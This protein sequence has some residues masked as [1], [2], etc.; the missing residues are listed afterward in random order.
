MS[1]A[2]F[3]VADFSTH[4]SGPVCSQLL[5]ELG[6]DVVKIENPR[7]GDGNR[8]LT[9]LIHDVGS[10]HIAMSSGTRSLAI[11]R[12]SPHWDDVVAA[13][14]RW[15]DAV[16]VGSRPI[17]AQARGLDFATVAKANP[18]I[19]YCLIT[20]YGEAG[21][22]KDY[23]AH[24]QNMDALAGLVPL[25]WNDGM[26]ATRPGFRTAGTTLAGIYAALGVM[27]GL[28]EQVREGGS[29]YVRVSV[30]GS[31]MAWQWRD[32]VNY[33]N[34]GEPWFEYR[35][36]GSRY[37][38]YPTSDE[39]AL[40]VC[41]I[42]RKF[43]QQFCAVTGLEQL[44]DRGSW[45][46]S[47]MDFGRGPDSED[48]RRTIAERLRTR[49]LSAWVEALEKTTIPFAPILTTQE[50]LQSE[51][52]AANNVLASTT[53]NGNPVKFAAS[54]VRVGR[55]DDGV[56]PTFSDVELSPPPGLGEQTD[57]VLSEIGLAELAGKL[58]PMP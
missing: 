16:I 2:R 1:E 58:G 18:E 5:T 37:G 56:A 49:P 6:A 21:P 42:E 38:I 40:L 25:E 50:A 47:G 27:A 3:R 11:D 17:D 55:S 30:W 14:A 23:T 57:E 45:D 32:V 39:R 22:W 48:E 53:V 8:G 35:D 43:W 12:H 20:G 7:V 19:V 9:P 51:H 34:T 41:P 15:A 4:L 28:Y 52:A 33:A 29:R 36:M 26:P 13:C 46:E 31:A 10:M 24:G 44:Q 54:P